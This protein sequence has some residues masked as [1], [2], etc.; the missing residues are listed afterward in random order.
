MARLDLSLR[1]CGAW[2][3]AAACHPRLPDVWS[4]A[5][6]DDA[7]LD[8]AIDA[9]P[10]MFTS[11][12]GLAPTCG[13]ATGTNDCCASAVVGGGTFLRSYDMSADMAYTDQTHPATVS[14]FRLDKYEVTVGRFRKFVA[15][16]LGTAANPPMAG[17][18]A[19]GAVAD[20]GWDASWNPILAPD[21]TA[22]SAAVKCDASY[23]TWT[24]TP[25]AN[26]SRPM[27]CIT[28]YEA[29]AF[30]A[31]DGGYLPT[32]TESMYAASGGN[33]QRAYPWSSPAGSGTIAC[34]YT[35]YAQNWNTVYCVA[36]TTD[37]GSESPTGDGVWGQSDL[38]GNVWEWVLD[39][40]ATPLPT[41]CND[42]ANLIATSLRVLRGGSFVSNAS[43]LRAARHADAA[44]PSARSSTYGVRCARTVP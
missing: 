17:V 31:W 1:V 12:D 8:G 5:P 11:C 2:L 38:G 16:G 36:G 40:Y 30:C 37:V 25:G 15:A 41:P 29:M 35:T 20:S 22:L 28:W 21:T 42:C 32:E 26:E 23:Q 27:N 14:N 7:S 4:D 3:V 44:P 18:G 33:L 24:D 34:T 39:W 6:A 43:T 10:V 9:L 19:H 13:G